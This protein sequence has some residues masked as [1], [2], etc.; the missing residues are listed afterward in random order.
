MTERMSAAEYRRG[1]DNRARARND[2]R[3]WSNAIPT[4]CSDG[5]RHASKLEARVCARLRGELTAGQVLYQQVRLPLLSIAAKDNGKAMYATIDFAIVEGGQLVRL[6]DAKGR[7]SPE[8]DRG[9]RAVEAAWG[10]P[11]EVITK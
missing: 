5:H 4:E 7:K 11:V 2:R 3:P 1:L 9:A 8:W 6:V 10:I